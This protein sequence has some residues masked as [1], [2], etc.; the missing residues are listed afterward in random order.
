MATEFGIRIKADASG[1]KG[2]V[3]EAKGAVEDFGRVADEAS[4]AVASKLGVAIGAAAVAVG[5][6]FV[7]QVRLGISALDDLDKAAQGLGIAGDKLSSLQTTFRA[8]GV[9]AQQFTGA[10]TRLSQQLADAA[11]GSPRAAALFDSM[12]ISVRDAAGN[13]KT[14]D[15]ALAEI[16]ERF[17]G[18]EDNALQANLATDLFGRTVG[19]KMIPTL[20]K[21]AEGL[22]E[23]TGASKEQIEAAAKL[24]G[25]IDKL[26][27]TW[28]R[29]WL[30]VA[31]GVARGINSVFD[32][33]SIEQQI[34]EVR[35]IIRSMELSQSGDP[36]NL[37]RYR[38]E[39][40]RLLNEQA[41]MM[42]PP[43]PLTQAPNV[44]GAPRG[45]RAARPGRVAVSETED[46]AE[47][48]ERE[49]LRLAEEVYRSGLR[50]YDQR[51]REIAQLEEQNQAVRNQ[52]EEFGKTESQVADLRAARLEDAAATLE[53]RAASLELQG[54]TLQDIEA[55]RAQVSLLRERAQLTRAAG[56]Q[57]QDARMA[58]EGGEALR[59]AVNASEQAA[60][61]AREQWSRYLTEAMQRGLEAG[62]GFIP[63]FAES[64]AN[65][66]QARL[67][68]AISEGLI[69]SLLRE[70]AGGAGSSGGL[71]AIGDAFIS[72]FGLAQGGVM[73]SAGP[74]P[75]A[76][77]ARGGVANRPQV[78]LFGEGSMNE[79]FVPLPD[80]RS[81]PVDMRGGG[82][83]VN[84]INNAGAQVS[85]RER[86][87]N[88]AL[89]VD[90]I[91]DQVEQAI[92]GNVM[93]GRGAL[94][95][96]IAGRFGL[97]Q[98]PR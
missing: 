56:S 75:L 90:V 73:T 12:G 6:F 39:L 82:V 49:R 19:T 22:T 58:R 35:Q 29:L 81:I 2:Q 72:I 84:V 5:G 21:G 85:T 25:E 53:Q 44:G 37:E 34:A 32:R 77:Y 86:N 52:I 66:V 9:S 36:R 17:R 4:V 30:S 16:A 27:A 63:A 74:L 96:A 97:R 31:G 23:L 38:A 24:Q 64:L 8:G 14:A 57:A 98:Q 69:D 65:T 41:A 42:G 61:E 80:G 3:G 48:L 10:M 92:A 40:E 79:A 50:A 54:A 51:A 33:G 78:A 94:G 13:V 83:T 68:A 43:A 95:G 67:A 11:A 47:R 45:S 62:K 91:V 15:V 26:A 88:G 71:D 55:L 60:G 28:D 1:F 20:N 46:E 87:D 18:Y 7:N 59:A 89:T 70:L 76:K 93:R